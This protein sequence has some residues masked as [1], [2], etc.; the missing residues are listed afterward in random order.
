MK[1]T[2]SIGLTAAALAVA[3]VPA[4]AQRN[5]AVL[6]DHGT[7]MMVDLLLVRPVSLVGS[8]IGF[9]GFLVSLPF[10]APTGS[11]PDAARA[12][13]GTPLEYTFNRPLGDFDNCGI[14]RHPCGEP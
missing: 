3:A 8:V 6:G 12:L 7:D 10:T 11:A 5:E 2:I 9:A 1:K 13:V 4:F 14:D